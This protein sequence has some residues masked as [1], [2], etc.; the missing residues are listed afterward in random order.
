M[1]DGPARGGK[2]NRKHHR[3]QR[4]PAMKRYNAERRDQVNKARHIARA[5]RSRDKAR[6]KGLRRIERAAERIRQ[7]EAQS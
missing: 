7:Q 3:S 6:R 1:S 5:L 2:K 4:S